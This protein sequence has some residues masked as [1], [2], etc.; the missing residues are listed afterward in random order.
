VMRAL[1]RVAALL[2]AAALTAP[3]LVSADE[4]VGAQLQRVEV[5]LH[6]WQVEDAAAIT[7]KLYARLPDVPAVQAAAGKVKFHQ[8]DYAGAVTLLEKAATAFKGGDDQGGAAAWDGDLLSLA[9]DTRD[10]TRGYLATDSEHFSFRA[11]PGRDQILAPYALEALEAAYRS[12]GEDFDWK[13]AGRVVVEAY[14][15]ARSLAQVSTLTEKEIETSGTIAI[16]K[17]NRL[18]FTSPR[19]LT[20]GYPWLDTLAHEYVHLVV[21]QKSHNSVGIWL[22]EGLAKYSESRWHGKAGEAMGSWQETLLGKA[23]KADKLITFEQMHP[24]MA[25]LPNQ[26]DT[27]LAFAEVFTVIEYLHSGGPA[28]ARKG[29][30]PGTRQGY[31]V[32]NAII[33]RLR[34]GQSHEEAVAGVLGTSFEAF[35]KDWLRYLKARPTRMGVAEAPKLEFKKGK[36]GDDEDRD[37]DVDSGLAAEVRR[38]ARLGNLL[39]EAGRPRAAA[40][41]YERAVSKAGQVTPVLHNRLASAYLE[42]GEDEKAL[43]T[44]RAVMSAAPDHGQTSIQL[45]RIHFKRQEW[46][47]AAEAYSNANRTNPFN[48]EI[49]AALAEVFARMDQ[50]ALSEREQGAYRVLMGEVVQEGG[51]VLVEDPREPHALLT[52]ETRPWAQLMLDDVDLGLMTPV[53]IRITPGAHKVRIRNPALGFDRTLPLQCAPG[54]KPTIRLDLTAP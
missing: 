36:R 46:L 54:D 38:F 5:L 9:R 1:A 42:A 13:P 43:Q 50:K 19:A 20:R 3:T 52:V 16:C 41:E 12:I 33:E 35:K 29:C 11:P 28:C 8:S 4:G 14:P 22:H 37:S 32:T 51:E 17:F 44:L 47:P 45:G 7:E 2:V 15:T 27:A 18:M 21:S 48:P 24:S 30:P 6:A 25:K 53:E 40:M 10:A 49:H 26:H 34:D 23:I 39:R 31:A